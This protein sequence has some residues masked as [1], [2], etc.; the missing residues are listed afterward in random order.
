MNFQGPDEMSSLP[1]NTHKLVSIILFIQEKNTNYV[2]II[3]NEHL[4]LSKFD[5]GQNVMVKW[6]GQNSSA[7]VSV[8]QNNTR[9]E[10]WYSSNR[11][12]GSQGLAIHIGVKAACF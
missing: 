8:Y 6:Q 3:E 4:D 5:K 2:F 11:L 1:K 7:V 10:Q 12:M 9:K